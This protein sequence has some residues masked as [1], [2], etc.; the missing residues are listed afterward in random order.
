VNLFFISSLV[1][2]DNKDVAIPVLRDLQAI[3]VEPQ[4]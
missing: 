3:T 2:N 1:R 4:G